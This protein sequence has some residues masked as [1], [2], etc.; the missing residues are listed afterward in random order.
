[1]ALKVTTGFPAATPQ[2]RDHNNPMEALILID[3]GLVLHNQGL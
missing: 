3:R 2:F 1:L